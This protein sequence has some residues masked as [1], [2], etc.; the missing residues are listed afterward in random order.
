MKFCCGTGFQRFENLEQREGNVF[1]HFKKKVNAYFTS[2]DSERLSVESAEDAL[3]VIG[4]PEHHC[5]SSIANTENEPQEDSPP[6][7]PHS[8]PPSSPPSSPSAVTSSMSFPSLA[9]PPTS[10][11]TSSIGLSSRLVQS[12]HTSPRDIPLSSTNA[13]P[14]SSPPP[15][16]PPSIQVPAAIFNDHAL[17]QFSE[18]TQV[19]DFFWY[20]SSVILIGLKVLCW[21]SLIVYNYMV[22]FMKSWLPV[23]YKR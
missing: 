11:P 21:P 14:A 19:R 4:S 9:L 20:L 12:P 7:S 16:C 6:S 10:T 3:V 13:I 23:R 5:S 15:M 8:S 17:M 2:T 18:V 1:I 22:Y